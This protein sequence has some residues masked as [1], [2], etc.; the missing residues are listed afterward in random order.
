M[1]L[2]QVVRAQREFFLTNQTKKPEFRRQQLIRLGEIIDEYERQIYQALYKDL[3]KSEYEAF[4]TEI[5]IVKQEIKN[6]LKHLKE[7]MKPVNKKSSITVFPNKSYTIYEPYGVVLIFS[8]WNYPFHL[9]LMPMIGAIAAGNCVILKA[10]PS[11]VH[12]TKLLQEMIKSNFS[13]HFLAAV[14][15]DVSYDSILRE[16]YDFIFFTGSA[17]VGKIVMRAA[18]EY[19]TPVVLELGGKCPCIVDK[20]ADVEKAARKIMWVKCINA[21]QTC[22]APDFILVDES[23]K[24]N[25]IAALKE[26]IEKY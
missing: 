10:S 11:S 2:D 7:W 13:S 4:L 16:R 3:N 9:S 25:M 5:S 20:S 12:T 6:A 1:R 23:I 26:E 15:D 8:P 14:E 22:V 18:S 24:E 19:L 21:G 17:R